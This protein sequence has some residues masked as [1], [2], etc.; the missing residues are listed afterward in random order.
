MGKMFKQSILMILIIAIALT[1]TT[2]SAGFV[3][4]RIVDS[5]SIA[6]AIQMLLLGSSLFIFAS[7]VR[8]HKK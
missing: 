1:A 5:Q 8:K 7:L 2:A 4:L 3:E 6:E